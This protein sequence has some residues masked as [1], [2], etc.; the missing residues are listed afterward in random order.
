MRN[1]GDRVDNVVNNVVLV[2]MVIMLHCVLIVQCLIV[3]TLST[4][5]VTSQLITRILAVNYLLFVLVNTCVH[6]RSLA[7]LKSKEKFRRSR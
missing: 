5:G 2:I 1:A 6:T 3:I 4:P 7:D